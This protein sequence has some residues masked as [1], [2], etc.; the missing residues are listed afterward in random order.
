MQPVFLD[1]ACKR[2]YDAIMLHARK[3]AANSGNIIRALPDPANPLGSSLDVS[4]RTVK[5]E[6]WETDARKCGINYV[7]YD[8]KWEAEL[9]RCLEKQ[10]N[11]VLAYVKNHGLGFE[12]PYRLNG[13]NRSYRPDFIVKIDMGEA[14]PLNLV[15][16]IKGLRGE[17]AKAKRLAM[18]N[19]WIPG[20]NNLG[21][22][23]KWAFLELTDKHEIAAKFA[24]AVENLRQGRI[25]TGSLL[26]A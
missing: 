11:H 16:E 26:D 1:D 6:L 20:V 18:E 9:C 4:F 2:I 25:E 10:D 7:V 24:R 17:D 3:H 23:G 5:T 19:Y 13:E 15:V 8:G 22:Y 14:E 21:E 12:V